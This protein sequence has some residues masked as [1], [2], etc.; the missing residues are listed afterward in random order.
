MFTCTRTHRLCPNLHLQTP[1]VPSLAPKQWTTSRFLPLNLLILAAPTPCHV[2][3]YNMATRPSRSL[4]G[5]HW[6]SQG[7]VLS[8]GCFLVSLAPPSPPHYVSPPLALE[9]QS[10]LK[11]SACELGR[12]R[13][14]SGPNPAAILGHP[15]A[16]C[17]GPLWPCPPPPAP[18]PFPATYTFSLS[19]CAACPGF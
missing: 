15:P 4:A 3:P 14:S 10:D 2:H 11:F 19:R 7:L 17:P 12:G 18:D 8:L 1:P 9:V 16:L 6:G 13:A 5:A